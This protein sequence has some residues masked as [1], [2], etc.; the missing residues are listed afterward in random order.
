MTLALTPLLPL[1]RGQVHVLR[2]RA[3]VWWVIWLA[4]ALLVEW[5]WPERLW[6]RGAVAGPVLLIALWRV[7]LV[8]QR[9]WRRC[10]YAFTGDELHVAQ[11]LLIEVLTI[12]PVRRVQHIDIVQGPVQRGFGL[13]TLVLHTAG[14]DA[15]QV[16]LSGL[17]RE[18]AEA[19]RD[20]IRATIGNAAE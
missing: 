19:I 8:P 6:F 13:C 4:V 18:T 14:S 12:V 16:R 15:N 2:I 20:A 17:T 7:L 1:E 11:G 3:A 10:G 5:V 9:K